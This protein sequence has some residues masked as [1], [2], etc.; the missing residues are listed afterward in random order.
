[1]TT[2]I[3][4][5]GPKTETNIEKYNFHLDLKDLLEKKNYR[6]RYERDFFGEK[7]FYKEKA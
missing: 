4:K 6:S 2:K 3:T 5:E 7:R 1:M